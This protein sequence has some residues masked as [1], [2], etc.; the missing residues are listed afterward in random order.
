M[1]FC[2]AC[3]SPVTK[4]SDTKFTCASCGREHYVNAK[5]CVAALLYT[6]DNHILLAVRG[7]EPHKGMLD[8]LGGF[9]DPGE[10]FEEALY[11]ELEEETGITKDDV[12]NVHYIGSTAEVYPWQG[13]D[14]QLT[15]AYFAATLKSG[16]TPTPK[17]D[18]AEIKEF[19]VSE[20]PINQVAFKGMRGLLTKLVDRS[21]TA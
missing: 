7:D 12:E 5:A 18:V 11:R 6:D 1:K 15:G 10:T 19:K 4:N 21:R 16:V 13:T 3:G 8:T 14:E 20:L 2:S 9:V 17:D